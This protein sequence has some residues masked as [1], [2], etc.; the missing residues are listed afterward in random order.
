MLGQNGYCRR[1]RPSRN[2]GI[3]DA[4]ASSLS[5]PRVCQESQ[6]PL[7]L[8][9]AMSHWEK[10]SV[11]SSHLRAN[12]MLGG[13]YKCLP[14]SSNKRVWFCHLPNS[15]SLCPWLWTFLPWPPRVL[16]GLQATG[17]PLK[18][19][20]FFKVYS[21]LHYLEIGMFL[22]CPYLKEKLKLFTYFE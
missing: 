3:C 12:E 8:D 17:Y 11:I 15:Q 4:D 22:I 9:Q 19:W 13:A 20:L 6:R 10:G 16:V 2:A 1:N 5:Q 7:K 18:L 14:S 21:R